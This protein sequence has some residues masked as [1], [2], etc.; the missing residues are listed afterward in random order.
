MPR[1]AMLKLAASAAACLGLADDSLGAA[2]A[3]RDLPRKIRQPRKGKAFDYRL[4]LGWINDNSN[5]PLAGK[6]WPITDIDEQTVQDYRAFLRAARDSGYNGITLWGLYA[7]HAWAGSS[8]KVAAPERRRL[9]DRIL[10]EADKNGHQGPL[11][12]GSL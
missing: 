4:M 1:R 3:P 5:R 10:K 12:P 6:R 9:I 8:K 7:S 2:L 11:R